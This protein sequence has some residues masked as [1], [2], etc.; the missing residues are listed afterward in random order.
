MALAV[1]GAGHIVVVGA[2]GLDT[3]EHVGGNERAEVFLLV[4]SLNANVHL[5]RGAEGIFVGEEADAVGLAISRG[6]GGAVGG[7]TN[8]DTVDVTE[9]AL[10]ESVGIAEVLEEGELVDAEQSVLLAGR[11]DEAAIFGGDEVVVKGLDHLA[12][13][14]VGDVSTVE[15]GGVGSGRA[16]G[17]DDFVS[18]G[19]SSEESGVDRAVEVLRQSVGSFL[20]VLSPQVIAALSHQD[21]FKQLGN[22]PVLVDDDGF[23]T[24]SD[25]LNGDGVGASLLIGSQVADEGNDDGVAFL[26]TEVDPF[27]EVGGDHVDF[28]LN[29]DLISPDFRNEGICSGLRRTSSTKATV[30]AVSL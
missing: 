20:G 6:E 26:P 22:F 2:Q 17:T 25:G 29:E 9:D 27:E 12:E 19:E 24:F 1:I 3:I 23:L 11:D 18:R 10:L 13:A 30:F 5:H 16:I 21:V 4:L 15:N 14:D 8:G 7:D 28:A